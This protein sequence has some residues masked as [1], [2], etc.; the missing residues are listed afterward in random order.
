M[1][2][3]TT[4]VRIGEVKDRRNRN[5]L[6]GGHPSQIEHRQDAR[7]DT[8]GFPV[9]LFW[10]KKWVRWFGQLP[11][12]S[13]RKGFPVFDRGQIAPLEQPVEQFFRN[14]ARH[15]VVAVRVA[16]IDGGGAQM[17]DESPHGFRRTGRQHILKVVVRQRPQ[18]G[19]D[20]FTFAPRTNDSIVDVVQTLVFENEPRPAGI[21]PR[22]RAFPAQPLAFDRTR[23]E[24]VDLDFRVPDAAPESRP[25]PVAR[26]WK[27]HNRC[28]WDRPRPRIS[29][30]Q[31]T[32]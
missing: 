15:E 28:G 25:A 20:S 10:V 27:R 16:F 5:F 3:F 19:L 17:R 2:R 12:K 6:F 18:R 26:P 29:H 24:G 30:R 9:D 14:L 11:Q 7:L 1:Q 22:S 31:S 32:S 23:R 21:Q 4:D 8:L 13:Q